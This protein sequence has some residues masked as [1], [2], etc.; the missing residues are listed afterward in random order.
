MCLLFVI[1]LFFG[2]LGNTSCEGPDF[3]CT[4]ISGKF[5]V[6]VDYEIVL[7]IDDELGV[8]SDMESF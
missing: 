8:V 2:K 3:F 7:S 4:N 5:V 6:F 1:D